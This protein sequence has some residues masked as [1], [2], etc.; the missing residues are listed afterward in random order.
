MFGVTTMFEDL[1]ALGSEKASK[2]EFDQI[3]NIATAASR[4]EGLEH[5]VMHTLPSGRK[6]RGEEYHVPHMDVCQTSLRENGR[7]LTRWFAS[8]T[9]TKLRI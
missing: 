7:M 9:K 5:F 1:M 8:R 3:M 4:V 2:K 6:L